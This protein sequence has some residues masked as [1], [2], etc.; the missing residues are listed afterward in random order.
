MTTSLV[1]ENFRKQVSVARRSTYFPVF[2]PQHLF[3]PAYLQIS[4]SASLRHV[5]LTAS[6]RTP[7][8]RFSVHV[9]MGSLETDTI[10]SVR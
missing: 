7:T 9:R 8:G 6:V 3:N 5:V 10:A 2:F 4:M 1:W